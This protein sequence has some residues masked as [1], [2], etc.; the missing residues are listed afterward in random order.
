MLARQW[1]VGEFEG[2]DAASP[3]KVNVDAS[4]IQ[5]SR[6]SSK[7]GNAVSYNPENLPL[8]VAVEKEQLTFSEL[9]YRLRAE[10]GNEFLKFVKANNIDAPDRLIL[11]LQVGFSDT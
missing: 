4:F 5:L 9:D 7:S 2:E 1:Q 11:L 6:F 10:L 8:E 3:A